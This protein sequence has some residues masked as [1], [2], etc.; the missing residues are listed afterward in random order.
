M[1]KRN[2]IHRR[3][4]SNGSVIAAS[5]EVFTL[6][7]QTGQTSTYGI[8][9]KKADTTWDVITFNYTPEGTLSN[10]GSGE[11]FFP[12]YIT[13]YAWYRSA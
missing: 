7:A 5:S 12:P 8:T 11:E 2:W 9:V 6:S 4:T 13:V 1:V 3:K 10:I